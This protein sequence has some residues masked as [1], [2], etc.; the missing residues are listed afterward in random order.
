M[1]HSPEHAIREWLRDFRATWHPA[2]TEPSRMRAETVRFVKHRDAPGGQIWYI[3][4]DGD[5]GSRGTERWAWTVAA[6]PDDEGKWSAHGV[7]GGGGSGDPV[8]RGRPWANLGGNWGS[9]GFRAGGTV[10]DGGAGIT[11]VRMTDASGRT[12]EDTVDNSVVLFASDEAVRMPMRVEL[13][14]DAG[15]V[16]DT[17]EWGFVDE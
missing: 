14:D 8:R 10:A 12:F 9:N 3:T 17:D 2:G 11:R 15:V 7:S 5:G 4:C 1:S 16:V 13:I 6:S